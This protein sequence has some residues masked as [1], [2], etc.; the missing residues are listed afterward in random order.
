M[1]LHVCCQVS[2][3]LKFLLTAIIRASNTWFFTLR[4][5]FNLY[6]YCCK[7]S[8]VLTNKIFHCSPILVSRFI[9][10]LIVEKQV[11]TLSISDL[12]QC[13]NNFVGVI[14]TSGQHLV[15]IIQ[16]H[17]FMDLINN[18]KYFWNILRNW[19]YLV[20]RALHCH[21]WQLYGLFD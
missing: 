3:L 4:H 19:E 20:M 5:F 7:K 21:S 14:G 16:L 6:I 17:M 15:R 11:V 2:I 18:G 12:L 1:R 13:R 9:V 8:L 10:F